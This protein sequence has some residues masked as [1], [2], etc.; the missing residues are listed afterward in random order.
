MS[1]NL[2][3]YYTAR[4]EWSEV[5]STQEFSTLDSRLV[6]TQTGLLADGT[7]SPP[8][9]RVIVGNM[10]KYRSAVTIFRFLWMCDRPANEFRMGNILL[11]SVTLLLFCCVL[12][13]I[14]LWASGGDEI[15]RVW[16]GVRW[17]SAAQ[18]ER[19][20]KMASRCFYG[21]NSS[22]IKLMPFFR[23]FVVWLRLVAGCD[24]WVFLFHRVQCGGGRCGAVC[25]SVYQ[26]GRRTF[27]QRCR[28]ELDSSV[29]LGVSRFDRS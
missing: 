2:F 17:G 1:I 14:S 6:V 4:Y 5:E 20:D 27:P 19:R 21:R 16:E 28:S 18:G 13:R 25:H 8:S 29:A 24:R 11:S 22:I 26:R 9:N 3:N 12:S 15:K 23:C 7:A 10:N